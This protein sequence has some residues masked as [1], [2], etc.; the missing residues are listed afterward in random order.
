MRKR[1]Y[2]GGTKNRDGAI[3]H[4]VGVT[5]TDPQSARD[6]IAAKLTRQKH[7]LG[8]SAVVTADQVGIAWIRDAN[9]E[10]MGR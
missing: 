8:W 4:T 1:H 7:D 3:T 2:I 10:E 9:P 5:A 6:L